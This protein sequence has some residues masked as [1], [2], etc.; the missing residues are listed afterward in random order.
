[1]QSQKRDTFYTIGMGILVVAVVALVGVMI[2]RLIVGRRPR[3]SFE[4][5]P[6][7]MATSTNVE[8]SGVLQDDALVAGDA[9][10]KAGVVSACDMPSGA[11]MSVKHYRS[12]GDI[13]DDYGQEDS[14]YR[15]YGQNLMDPSVYEQEVNS[16]SQLAM[17]AISS[18]YYNMTLSN[19]IMGDIL[20]K[21]DS[22][23][24]Q[25]GSAYVVQAVDVVPP[26]NS[27]TGVGQYGAGGV[28]MS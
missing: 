8:M 3:E 26:F 16:S 17:R 20:P 23:M 1:M 9:V 27:V 25:D 28:D 18:P 22:H 11:G 12:S 21:P 14:L 4:D 2:Y 19:V 10:E 6:K 24:S 13:V 15:P 7:D 5:L